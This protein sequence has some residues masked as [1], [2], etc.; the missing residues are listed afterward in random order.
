LAWRR[1]GDRMKGPIV[2]ISVGIALCNSMAVAA[3]V[4]VLSAGAVEPGLLCPAEQFERAS[5]FGASR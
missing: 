3:D 2:A 4:K 1:Q 5:S